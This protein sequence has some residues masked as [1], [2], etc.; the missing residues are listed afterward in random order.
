MQPLQKAR[1]QPPFSP[2][3]GSLCRP[4]ITTTHFRY[5]FSIFETS[6]TVLRGPTGNLF[7]LELGAFPLN[8]QTKII[9]ALAMRQILHAL[10]ER[11]NVETPG[12]DTENGLSMG[13]MQQYQLSRCEYKS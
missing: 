7:E 4:R 6:A 8:C 2:S 3:V 11:S 10:Q 12:M 9:Q 1:H 5:R 13:S